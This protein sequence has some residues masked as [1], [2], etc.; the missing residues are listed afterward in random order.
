[1]K[2]NDIFMA[3]METSV[4]VS[5]ESKQAY[6]N[7]RTMLI[8]KLKTYNK[9]QASCDI[10]SDLYVQASWSAST[11]LGTFR[12]LEQQDRLRSKHYD[13]GDL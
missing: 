11:H 9:R 1:M 10:Y 4:A 3:A 7:L 12:I 2:L 5:F 13:V 6:D 8:R